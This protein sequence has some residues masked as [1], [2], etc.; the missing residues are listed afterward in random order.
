MDAAQLIEMSMGEI[1]QVLMRNQRRLEKELIDAIVQ[2]AAKGLSHRQIAKLRG[3]PK[4]KVGR[5][6]SKVRGAKNA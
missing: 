3:C 4:S 2:D 5:V 6:L 1:V